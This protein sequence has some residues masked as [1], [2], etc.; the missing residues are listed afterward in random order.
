MQITRILLYA[1]ACAVPLAAQTTR[2][3]QILPPPIETV[4]SSGFD[5]SQSTA[6]FV[7]VRHFTHDETLAEV[8]YAVDDAIDLAFVS[9]L[10][11]N[12]RLVDAGRVI[13]ALSG[14]P[15][16]PE[17]QQKL[18]ALRAAGATVRD[19]GETDILALL[20]RQAR[21]AGRKGILIA[22]IAT[23]GFNAGGVHYLL[24]AN[25]LFEHRE[26]SISTNKLLDI[27]GQ[28]NA[29]RSLLFLDACR[30]RLVSGERSEGESDPRSSAPLVQAMAQARGEV[31]FYA[32]AAGQ[33][34][35]DDDPRKNG[36]FT[37]AVIDGMR[38]AAAAN[39][40]GLIT[41]DALSDYVNARVLTWIRKHRDAR[42]SKGIQIL[43]DASSKTMPLATCNRPKGAMPADVRSSDH[44]FNVLRPACG[45]GVRRSR[46]RSR[47]RRW[48]TWTATAY[49]R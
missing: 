2:S 45:S 15:Q 13:L 47:K 3:A 32:A 42:A 10:D 21:N 14:E 43:S 1:F 40:R 38:C 37:A 39:P 36:V 5:R 31:V 23:H 28:S 29:L 34:A 22:S 49:E 24:A 44:I 6:L 25:S 19:A 12:V 48:R 4:E 17:S 46:E 35:Y 20:E 27:A 16:K 11:R 30:G 26:T 33:Y 41:V 7:G 8:R 18:D 9:A